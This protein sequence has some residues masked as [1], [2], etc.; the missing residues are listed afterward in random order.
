MNFHKYPLFYIDFEYLNTNTQFIVL[1]CFKKK[2][3]KSI[4]LYY[5]LNLI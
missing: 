2:K 1:F 4:Y 5:Y 3:I